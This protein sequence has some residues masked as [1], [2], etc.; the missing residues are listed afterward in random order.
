MTSRSNKSIVTAL[1]NYLYILSSEP[2]NIRK[3]IY[4]MKAIESLN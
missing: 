1:W 2:Q 4:M 3:A